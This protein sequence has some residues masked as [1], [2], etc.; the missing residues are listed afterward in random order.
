MTDVSDAFGGSLRAD[1]FPIQEGARIEWI[2][3]PDTH[4]VEAESAS[5]CAGDAGS[6]CTG[7]ATCWAVTSDILTLSSRR[8]RHIYSYDGFPS[9]DFD[10]E[11]AGLTRVHCFDAN[12]LQDVQDAFGPSMNIEVVDQSESMGGSAGNQADPAG[13][14]GGPS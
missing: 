6:Y 4:L 1:P 10:D 2:A 8:L 14:G 9:L 13:D 7:K 5:Y 11:S 12:T 3:P